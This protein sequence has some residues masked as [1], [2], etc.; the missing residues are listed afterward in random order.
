MRDGSSGDSGT[1]EPSNGLQEIKFWWG[2]RRDLNFIPV[3]GSILYLMGRA[4]Q[5]IDGQSKWRS[6]Y[7]DSKTGKCL[8]HKK[9]RALHEL[10]H[11]GIQLFREGKI[12]DGVEYQ[13]NAYMTY[14]NVS[15]VYSLWYEN[16]LNEACDALNRKGDSFSGERRFVEAAEMYELAAKFC[17]CEHQNKETFSDNLL[18]AETEIANVIVKTSLDE[19]DRSAFD[20][21]VE[22]MKSRSINC[23]DRVAIA[24]APILSSLEKLWERAWEADSEEEE[25]KR[26]FQRVSDEF[27]NL[28]KVLP[29]PP[30]AYAYKRLADL[31]IEANNLVKLGLESKHRGE[32]LLQE[33]QR[34]G[35][36]RI[37]E[38]SNLKFHEA[39]DIF[40][41]ASANFQNG[42]ES[43]ERF[44]TSVPFVRVQVDEIG[45]SI[46]FI[47]RQSFVSALDGADLDNNNRSSVDEPSWRLEGQFC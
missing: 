24:R 16:N 43:D 21:A 23:E 13:R 6:L 4:L 14:L 46:G 30:P 7:F 29:V 22:Y 20:Q 33:A 32:K 28:E 38:L 39:M 19:E 37:Y 47:S 17:T 8:S 18:K 11:K 34:T 31:K 27:E 12:A 35:L 41:R 36:R 40:T 10:S 9:H 26:L 15:N 1:L 42:G 25:A 2:A 3:A 5:K 44:R 45:R